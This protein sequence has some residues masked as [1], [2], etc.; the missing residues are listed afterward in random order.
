MSFHRKDNC[1]PL[2]NKVEE[3]VRVLDVRRFV[4]GN[5]KTLGELGDKARLGCCC[6]NLDE[7]VVSETITSGLIISGRDWSSNG[8]CDV[9]GDIADGS[10]TS[11]GQSSKVELDEGVAQKVTV[12][13][14]V[15]MKNK[16]RLGVDCRCQQQ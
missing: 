2:Q 1:F 13:Y 12:K 14:S 16:A 11:H 9:K 8:S 3:V 5:L 7:D 6:A 10:A 15:T 4:S